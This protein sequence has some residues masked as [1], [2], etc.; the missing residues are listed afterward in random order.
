MAMAMVMPADADRRPRCVLEQQREHVPGV[1]SNARGR[2]AADGRVLRSLSCTHMYM[3]MC[4]VALGS[5]SI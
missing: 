1:M 2:T 4:H 3:Y 5:D